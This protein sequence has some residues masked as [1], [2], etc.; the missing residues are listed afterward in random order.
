MACVE[1][2]GVLFFSVFMVCVSVYVWVDLGDYSHQPPTI[3][4]QP[5][6]YQPPSYQPP[7]HQSPSHQP[8]SHLATKFNFVDTFFQVAQGSSVVSGIKT[9][10][11]HGRFYTNI[12]QFFFINSI[13]HFR[14]VFPYLN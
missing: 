5:S 4:H 14:G 7:S 1:N 3:S 9:C 11:N 12:V 6:S 8:P 13:F 2:R 10:F